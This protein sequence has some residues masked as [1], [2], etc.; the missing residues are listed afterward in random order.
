MW[1]L[2][3]YV[4]RLKQEMEMATSSLSGENLDLY[5]ILAKSQLDC[6]VVKKLAK[7]REMNAG[8]GVRGNPATACGCGP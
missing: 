8:C 7:D 5:L 3:F 1:E 2:D 6:A 4:K